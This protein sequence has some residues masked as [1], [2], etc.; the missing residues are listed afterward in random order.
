MCVADCGKGC[1]I[2]AKVAVLGLQFPVDCI[3]AV[4][5]AETAGWTGGA[6]YIK[7]CSDRCGTHAY[8]AASAADIDRGREERRSGRTTGAVADGVHKAK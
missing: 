5:R 3:D 1:V 2:V 6:F 4:R 8:G 7:C